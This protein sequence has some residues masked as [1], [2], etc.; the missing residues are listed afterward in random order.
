MAPNE[1]CA[2]FSL[3]MYARNISF[4]VVKKSVMLLFR[5]TF[6]LNLELNV[7]AKL[8]VFRWELIVL[9]LMQ[10]CFYFAMK[11]FS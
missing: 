2:F 11:E 7:I 4:G 5:I 6:L 3:L 9:F 8:L 10:I 1:E